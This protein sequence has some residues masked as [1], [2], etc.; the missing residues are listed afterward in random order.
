MW[1]KETK[2][3]FIFDFFFVLYIQ[4]KQCRLICWSYVLLSHPSSKLTW[5][6]HKTA[7]I[8]PHQKWAL[9]RTWRWQQFKDMQHRLGI[10][11]VGSN[12]KETGGWVNRDYEKKKKMERKLYLWFLSS[13]GF[14]S[15]CR[16]WTHKPDTGS[17][18]HLSHHSFTF[19]RCP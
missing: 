13:L 9:S 14:W 19:P 15:L 16:G 12:W 8:L 4:W 1:V 2:F 6:I 17:A 10:L 7:I 5:I 18:W 11:L 3:Y